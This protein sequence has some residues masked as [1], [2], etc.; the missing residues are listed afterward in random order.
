[1]YRPPLNLQ[2]MIITNT[3]NL[4]IIR[5][6]SKQSIFVDQILTIYF[7]KGLSA[8]FMAKMFWSKSSVLKTSEDVIIFC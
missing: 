1:M 8:A 3:W 6:P 7:E 5:M 4:E 2:K